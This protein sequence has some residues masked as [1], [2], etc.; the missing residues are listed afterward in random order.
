MAHNALSI[1]TFRVCRALL[2]EA[3][4][5]GGHASLSGALWRAVVPTAMSPLRR[6]LS[7]RGPEWCTLPLSC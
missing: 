4:V 6:T 7:T 3:K 5:T 2:Q 1:L